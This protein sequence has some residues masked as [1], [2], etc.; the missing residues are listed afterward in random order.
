[1]RAGRRPQQI[2]RTGLSNHRW[3]VEGTLCLLRKQWEV[4][5]AWDGAT[6]PVAEHTFPWLIDR[7]KSA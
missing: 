2:G 4:I 6:T 5:V 7:G 3:I 1:M